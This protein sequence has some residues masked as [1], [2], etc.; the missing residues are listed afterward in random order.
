L[1]KI[2]TYDNNNTKK[3]KENYSEVSD[4]SAMDRQ[5][6]LSEDTFRR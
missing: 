6:T 2:F 4:D 3:V 5:S 1:N